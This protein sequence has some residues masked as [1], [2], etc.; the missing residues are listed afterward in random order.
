MK[1]FN[2]LICRFR[3]NSKGY[4]RTFRYFLLATVMAC[5]LDMISTIYFMSR[6]GTTEEIHPAIRLVS[7]VFGPII[8]PLLGKTCQLLGVILLTIFF[9][10]I[11]KYIFLVI[12]ILYAW[13]SWYNIWG[14]HLYVPRFM[15]Y[16]PI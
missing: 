10:S 5:L 8:G 13:A 2:D 6:Y 15:Q 1:T 16:L 3:N 14:H 11:A 7:L 9:R 12:I 4:I